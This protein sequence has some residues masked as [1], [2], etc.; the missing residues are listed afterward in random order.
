MQRTNWPLATIVGVITILLTLVA[1]RVYLGRSDENNAVK[2]QYLEK[3]LEEV[4]QR[5]F[6][7]EER[8]A[9]QNMRLEILE[10]KE[11]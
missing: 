7:N 5:Q 2:I 11:K 3:T 6:K 4:R 8:I 9:Q 1:D 10:L